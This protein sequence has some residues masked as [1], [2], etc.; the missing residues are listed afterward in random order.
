L[1]EVSRGGKKKVQQGLRGKSLRIGIEPSFRH[2]GK[3]NQEKT[4]KR[5]ISGRKK[6]PQPLAQNA[7]HFYLRRKSSSVKSCRRGEK[8]FNIKEEARRGRKRHPKKEGL[9]RSGSSVVSKR[10]NDVPTI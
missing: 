10:R 9:V 8:H 6:K 7:A 3:K 2:G 1:G 5:I 4:L